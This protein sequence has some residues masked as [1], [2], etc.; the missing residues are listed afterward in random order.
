MNRHEDLFSDYE[1]QEVPDKLPGTFWAY[2]DICGEFM[3]ATE[4]KERGEAW[5]ASKAGFVARYERVATN[6]SDWKP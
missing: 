6:Q 5:I 3:E 2:W 1:P 4:D